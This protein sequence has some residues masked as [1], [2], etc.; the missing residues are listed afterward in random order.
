MDFHFLNA[1]RYYSNI[2][3]SEFWMGQVYHAMYGL[4]VGI[5][6]W[7]AEDLTAIAAAT[8]VQISFLWSV[9]YNY[10]LIM[11]SSFSKTVYIPSHTW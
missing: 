10:N 11:Q 1:D 7:A 2:W 6:A 3:A 4:G 5:L 8:I 9:L